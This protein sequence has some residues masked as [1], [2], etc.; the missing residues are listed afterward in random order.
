MADIPNRDSL[1]ARLA[2]ILARL[3]RAQMARLLELLGDPPNMANVPQ[4]FWD[5]TGKE[6]QQ[7]LGPF[8]EQVYL[9][10][11]GLLM[12]SIP[13]GVDWA[14]INTAAVNWARAYTFDLVSGIT[15]T[16]RQALQT[17]VSAYFER[18]QTIGE[19]ERS[20]SG[21]YGPVRSEMIAVT[22][23][24]RASSQGEL[25]IA[26][27]LRKEGVEMIAIWET[28]ADEKVCP[29][30]APRN[31]KKEGDGWRDPPPAHPRCR[32]W[33]NHELPKVRR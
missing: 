2:R 25:Q 12:A 21:L 9:D 27:D 11:A 3:Q 14:L 7:A 10:Q 32:C 5:E 33:I 31:G 19:L 30:C 26:E 1:E 29:I 18:G 4:S 24:T 23:V 16:T 22:E 13:I 20:I 6:L 15:A 17:S 8:L 28:S